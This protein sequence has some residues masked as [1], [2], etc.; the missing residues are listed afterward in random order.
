MNDIL[1]SFAG[2]YAG[3]AGAAAGMAM[4]TFAIVGTIDFIWKVL[5]TLLSEENQITL[6]VQCSV[7]YGMIA[8][9]IMNYLAWSRLF[10]KSLMDAGLAVGGG[11]IGSGALTNPDYIWQTGA[12]NAQPL[13]EV[14]KGTAS[15]GAIP[16]A[17]MCL[18]MYV[19]LMAC[20]LLI[21]CQVFI[22]WLEWYIIG[23]CAVIF[24]PFL[25]ND[26]TKFMGEKAIGAI[27]AQGVKLM[28]LGVVLSA[29]MPV[30]G[31]LALPAK[32][33]VSQCILPLG[34]IAAMAFLAWHA[35]GV[36]AGLLAGSPSLSFDNVRS[37]GASGAGMFSRPGSGGSGG[38]RVPT[39]IPD[40]IKKA[41][42]G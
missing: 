27:V 37:A 32:A 22:T 19:I 4:S 18:V 1:A 39:T 38:R 42:G 30:L 40:G 9:L 8:A 10:L 31:S 6:L 11:G 16:V 15:L 34:K 25:A 35:P 24:F 3:G 28:V 33:D 5:K 17:L 14:V 7:K 29:V 41:T 21:A 12:I 20:Y 2:M 36:A 26:N 23:G 13:L